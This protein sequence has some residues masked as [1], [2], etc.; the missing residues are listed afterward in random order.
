[1]RPEGRNRG[2]IAALGPQGVHIRQTTRA[3][4]TNTKC[5][6]NKEESNQGC[7]R[8]TIALPYHCQSLRKTILVC[9]LKL[10]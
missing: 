7:P 5:T 4:V 1:M 9:Y 3:H 8:K 10:V 6:D 2:P